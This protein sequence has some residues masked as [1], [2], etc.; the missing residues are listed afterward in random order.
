MMASALHMRWLGLAL[1]AVALTSCEDGAQPAPSA[2]SSAAPSASAEQTVAPESSAAAPSPIVA[3][4]FDWSKV[5][6][7]ALKSTYSPGDKVWGVT[8]LP[9][10]ETAVQILPAV[11]VESSGNDVTLRIGTRKTT[12]P[13]SM[14]RAR[15]GVAD[16]EKGTPVLAGNFFVASYARVVASAANVTVDVSLPGR[17]TRR[18]IVRDSVL[19]LDGTLTFAAPVHFKDGDSERFGVLLYKGSDKS[20]VADATR[21]IKQVPTASLQPMPIQRLLKK[22]DKVRALAGTTL[23]PGTI[24]E[25]LGD[26]VLYRLDGPN[27]DSFSKAGV[28]FIHVMPAVP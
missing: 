5:E 17:V 11:V 26:G 22:G 9:G 13:A 8:P 6:V 14:T 7:P 18:D 16:I 20:Y 10:S 27:A 19:P 1:A 12:V 3:D 24:K 2:A 25:V 21:F 15:P 4:K 28:S 23:L